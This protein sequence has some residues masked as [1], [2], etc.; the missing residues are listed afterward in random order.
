[1]ICIFVVMLRKSVEISFNSFEFL[2]RVLRRSTLMK[3]AKRDAPIWQI[4][5]SNLGSSVVDEPLC[6][7]PRKRIAVVD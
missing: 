2:L 7:M 1:M 5:A 3:P 4:F 6:G